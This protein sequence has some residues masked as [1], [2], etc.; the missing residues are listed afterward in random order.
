LAVVD[1]VPIIAPTCS[2]RQR[3]L[4]AKR[5]KLG[6]LLP[7]RPCCGSLSSGKDAAHADSPV[8][9]LPATSAASG[10]NGN[11]SA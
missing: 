6:H 4:D 2:E 7:A 8:Q 10:S 11:R 1:Q 9:S 3:Y 5:D